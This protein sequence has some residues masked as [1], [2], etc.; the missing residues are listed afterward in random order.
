[1]EKDAVFRVAMESVNVLTPVERSSAFRGHAQK[2]VFNA[3]KQIENKQINSTNKLFEF[4]ERSGVNKKDFENIITDVIDRSKDPDDIV[5]VAMN[6]G[7]GLNGSGLGLLGR[8]WFKRNVSDSQVL[9][10]I[11]PKWWSLF[12]NDDW[13]ETHKVTKE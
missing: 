7:E 1:M 10:I 9:K 5:S 6:L 2:V 11:P 12:R 8:N 13:V 3:L 4:L